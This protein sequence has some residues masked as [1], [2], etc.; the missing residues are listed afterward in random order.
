MNIFEFRRHVE[1]VTDFNFF[2]YDWQRVGS[3]LQKRDLNIMTF[4]IAFIF[5][6]QLKSNGKEFIQKL[7]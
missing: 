5:F 3:Q 7:H 2:Q 1:S 4:E 6:K